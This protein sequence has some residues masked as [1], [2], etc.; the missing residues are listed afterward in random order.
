MSDQYPAY[1][2]AGAAYS[3]YYQAIGLPAE[4]CS[5]NWAIIVESRP[6]LVAMWDA[7]AEAA[8]AAKQAI[9]AEALVVEASSS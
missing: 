7:T 6:D 8:Y 3:A 2:V 4:W 5:A 9:V 1:Y